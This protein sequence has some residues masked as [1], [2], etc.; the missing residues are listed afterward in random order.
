MSQLDDVDYMI[1]RFKSENIILS[2]LEDNEDNPQTREYI[3]NYT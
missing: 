3:C 2:Y 1:T